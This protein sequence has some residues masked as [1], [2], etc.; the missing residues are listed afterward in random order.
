M[1]RILIG[2]GVLLIM[3]GV[4]MLMLPKVPW[5]GRLPGDILMKRG[6]MTVY[7]PVTTCLVLSLVF[8]L[9]WWLL[10]RFR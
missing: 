5:V 4:I 8:S 3:A 7:F 1:A 6:G 9:V 2:A 10:S